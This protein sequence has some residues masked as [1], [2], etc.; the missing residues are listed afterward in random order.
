MKFP[1]P[2]IEGRLI[3]RYKRFLADVELEDGT[4]I[5][6]HCPNPGAMMGLKDPGNRVWISDSGNPKRKL[7]HTLELV[8]ARAPSGPVLVGINTM[9]PNRL[10]KEALEAGRITQLSGFTHLR[11]EVP[12]GER[13]RIDILLAGGTPNDPRDCYIEV[14]NVHLVREISLHEFP[15]C[16][17]ERGAKHLR[18]MA[19]M[20]AQ[21]HRAV[22]LYV[23][24][25]GDGDRFSLAS[26]LDPAYAEAFVAA[27]A[28]GVEALAIR[29]DITTT[30][31]VATT[32]IPILV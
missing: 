8:E 21:G 5:T 11:T 16:K 28:A 24:Q 29:C 1:T 17:T 27:R 6:V 15:D 30:E 19:N 12:Y 32:P 23:V 31:I 14:K 4:I 9:L 7:R 25:R 3:E 22:M 10:A 26:D 13:S 20:V 18:E 2:L